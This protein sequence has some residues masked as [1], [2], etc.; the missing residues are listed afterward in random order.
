MVVKFSKKCLKKAD[1][2]ILVGYEHVGYR[3]LVNK[4]IIVA[5]QMF[6]DE[7]ESLVGF[8]GEDVSDDESVKSS[9]ENSES[10][11]INENVTND[12]NT[13]NVK[14]K[15]FVMSSNRSDGSIDDVENELRRSTREIKKTRKV[16]SSKFPLHLCKYSK[17]I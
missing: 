10:N 9:D 4:K 15:K 17:R 12:E 14:S 3:V 5:R 1:I 13:E 11:E 16:W 6:L 8:E 7:N 2:G